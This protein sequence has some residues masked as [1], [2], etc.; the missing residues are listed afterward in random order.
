MLNLF[1]VLFYNLFCSKPSGLGGL[2]HRPD[3]QEILHKGHL[4]KN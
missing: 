3:G 4:G 1:K 2:H